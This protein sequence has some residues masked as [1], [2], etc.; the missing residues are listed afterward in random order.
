MVSKNV[1]L[2]QPSYSEKCWQGLAGESDAGARR[3][4]ERRG[5]GPVPC[6]PEVYHGEVQRETDPE[7]GG[8]QQGKM[9]SKTIEVKAPPVESVILF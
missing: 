1:D 8:V 9:A 4:R 3:E 5:R 6:V 2:S 7:G